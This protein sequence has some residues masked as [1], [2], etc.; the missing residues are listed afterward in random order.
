MKILPIILSFLLFL[1]L[2][3]CGG[4]TGSK[5]EDY[6]EEYKAILGILDKAEFSHDDLLKIRDYIGFFY[7]DKWE[8]SQVAVNISEINVDNDTVSVGLVEYNPNTV[9]AFFEEV[10]PDRDP[11]TLP[12]IFMQRDAW[13]HYSS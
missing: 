4:T 3:S 9:A 1:P 7:S 6:T 13:E 10:F 8:T 12:L 5:E 2:A 11:D